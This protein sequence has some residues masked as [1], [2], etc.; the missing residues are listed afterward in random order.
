MEEKNIKICPFCGYKHNENTQKKCSRC[1]HS[2]ST[3]IMTRYLPAYERRGKISTD[4]GTLFN[5]IEKFNA[6]IEQREH[7]EQLIGVYQAPPKSTTEQINEATVSAQYYAKKLFSFLFSFVKAIC[8]FIHPVFAITFLGTEWLMSRVPE[9]HQTDMP[10]FIFL[11]FYIIALLITWGSFDVL[12]QWIYTIFH[13]KTVKEQKAAAK[14]ENEE[15]RQRIL[16]KIEANKEANRKL[17]EQSIA[18]LP[19]FKEEYWNEDDVSLLLKCM[20]N[21]KVANWRSAYDWVEKHAKP[22]KAKIAREKAKTVK[23]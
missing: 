8:L 17:R 11:F 7:L 6:N 4:I 12:K 15:Y 3:D 9:F 23:Y 20:Y 13:W 1:G 14:K 10:T 18:K 19:G 2:L 5:D 22:E 16:A 21:T